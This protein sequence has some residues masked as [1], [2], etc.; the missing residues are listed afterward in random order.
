MRVAA[1]EGEPLGVALSGRGFDVAM[2]VPFGEPLATGLSRAAL[3]AV[4]VCPT[5]ALALRRA[6]ACEGCGAGGFVELTTE[7]PG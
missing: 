3:R 5:A 7:L 6:R 1:D 2:G 4:E